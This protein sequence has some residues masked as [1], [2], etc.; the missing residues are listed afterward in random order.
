[1]DIIHANLQKSVIDRLWKT[2]IF[3]ILLHQAQEETKIRI[4]KEK[5]S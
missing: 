1:M 4:L 5:G 2:K 3:R